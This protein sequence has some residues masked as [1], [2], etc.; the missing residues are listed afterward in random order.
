MPKGPARDEWSACH[1]NLYQ[2]KQAW[3]NS[4]M[5]PKETYTTEQ[6]KEVTEAVHAFLRQ[7]STLV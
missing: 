4:T 6:A 3:R 2:V 1:V 7:L 5:H